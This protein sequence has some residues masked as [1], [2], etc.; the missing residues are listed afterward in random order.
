MLGHRGIP[1][2]E[3]RRKLPD[4]AFPVDELADDQQPVTVGERLQ[5]V[6]CLVCSL[7]HEFAMYLHNH[8]HMNICIYGQI[9]TTG[10]R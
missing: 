10:W 2:V 6:A 8:I 3:Q 1:Q 5:E 7:L 9:E 4:R